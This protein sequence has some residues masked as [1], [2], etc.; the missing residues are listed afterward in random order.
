[1]DRNPKVLIWRKVGC[2]LDNYTW[3]TR[4]CRFDMV[5]EFLDYDL[6]LT[7]DKL[8]LTVTEDEEKAFNR[9]MVDIL[10]KQFK[11]DA[12]VR[13]I[14]ST[15]S[16]KYTEARAHLNGG[17]GG[18][19]KSVVA[20]FVEF[21][22]EGRSYHLSRSFFYD[23]KN[24]QR[25]FKIAEMHLKLLAITDE[26]EQK[27]ISVAPYKS[28][29]GGQP[30][31][32]KIRNKTK[33]KFNNKTYYFPGFL[34]WTYNSSEFMIR[35]DRAITRRTLAV[36][37]TKVFDELPSF[38]DN[39][40][41]WPNRRRPVLLSLALKYLKRRS[42]WVRFPAQSYVDSVSILAPVQTDLIVWL[43]EHYT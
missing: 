20:H 2:R 37:Y 13:A 35:P 15:L 41:A 25:M 43:F 33:K 21:T 16:P 6:E 4:G 3:F 11:V 30:S 9:E 7:S 29:P 17:I 31:V 8:S 14:A 5:S 19:L 34:L 24:E 42:G 27:P 39:M 38:M 1:M 32:G 40:T 10:G 18:N 28:L 22:F 36:E 12:L 26:M 23:M